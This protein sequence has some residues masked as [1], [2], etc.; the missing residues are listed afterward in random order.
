MVVTPDLIRGPP[1]FRCPTLGK[2]RR[3]I[4]RLGMHP[5]IPAML[6]LFGCGAMAPLEF[7]RLRDQHGARDG[8]LGG[9]G[10]A[11]DVAL[12]DRLQRVG[13]SDPARGAGLEPE[14]LASSRAATRGKT[15]AEASTTGC[16]ERAS[17]AIASCPAGSSK[18]AAPASATRWCS[19]T[20]TATPRNGR[21]RR[22]ARARLTSGASFRPSPSAIP[23]A[24]ARPSNAGK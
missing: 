18:R 23:R 4:A 13:A 1:A 7:R 9:L 14:A 21:A 19:P 3:G 12:F 11:A 20:R 24:T 15:K 5:D 17:A 2:C 8:P 16:R 22:C 6:I 10:G